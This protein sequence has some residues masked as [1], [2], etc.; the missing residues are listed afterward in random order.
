M[1]RGGKRGI[2][3]GQQPALPHLFLPNS[4]LFRMAAALDFPPRHIKLF[5]HSNEYDSAG[6]VGNMRIKEEPIKATVAV[7]LCLAL[8]QIT[9]TTLPKSYWL[10]LTGSEPP[11]LYRMEKGRG[12]IRRGDLVLMDIP[13]EFHRYVYGRGWIPEGWPL[14]KHVGGVAGDLFCVA[15]SSFAVNGAEVGPVFSMDEEGL[16][17]PHLSG[18][19]RIPADRFLPVAVRIE[20]SFDGRYMGPVEIDRIRGKLTPIWT[21]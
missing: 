7:L 10:N 2:A 8:M 6:E 11:G 18:C 13:E 14:I 3:P 17:L 20:R 4:R 15:G 5:T 19:Q 16:P 9:T 1:D 21:K 12:E